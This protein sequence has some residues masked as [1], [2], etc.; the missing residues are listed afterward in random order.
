MTGGELCGRWEEVSRDTQFSQ[1]TLEVL[2]LKYGLT[3]NPCLSSP[4]VFLQVVLPMISVGPDI[5]QLGL[6]EQV[7]MVIKMWAADLYSTQF[8]CVGF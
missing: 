4:C 8:L 2:L 6:T 7:V 5:R 3:R 1:V